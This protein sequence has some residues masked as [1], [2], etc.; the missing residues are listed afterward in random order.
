MNEELE[1][2][3]W[4]YVENGLSQEQKAEIE[5]KIKEDSAAQKKFE[6]IKALHH[7]LKT[8]PVT[9]PEMGLG[10]MVMN[11]ITNSEIDAQIQ[12]APGNDKSLIPIILILFGGLILASIIIFYFVSKNQGASAVISEFPISRKTLTYV[13]YMGILVI[14]VLALHRIS[15]NKKNAW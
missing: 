3:I 2:L 4:Q 14:I 9:A 5:N 10:N 8:L 1:Y 11:Q 13:G 15:F 12:S 6:D 7:Q